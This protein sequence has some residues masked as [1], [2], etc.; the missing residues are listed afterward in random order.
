M[1]L[2]K[3]SLLANEKLRVISG[4]I[5]AGQSTVLCKHKLDT[6][7]ASPLNAGIYI[8]QNINFVNSFEI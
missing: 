5:R 6:F 2:G 7:H 8:Y 1:S 3:A 4:P